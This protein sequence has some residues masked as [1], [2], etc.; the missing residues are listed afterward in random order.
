MASVCAYRCVYV[1]PN[2]FEMENQS[3]AM[4]YVR[5]NAITHVGCI[6]PQSQKRGEECRQL[7]I[8]L[9][10]MEHLIHYSGAANT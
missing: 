6:A 4:Y 3:T 1:C 2:P 9:M 8:V 10:S 7:F 5:A